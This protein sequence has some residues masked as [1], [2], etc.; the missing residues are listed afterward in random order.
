MS[1]ILVPN[2]T[3]KTVRLIAADSDCDQR[4]AARVLLGLPT[5]PS[6]R[7]RVIAAA[8]KLGIDLPKPGAGEGG[9]Q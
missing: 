2:V 9:A 7:E 5:R 6:L 1:M 3:V 4:T 8:T